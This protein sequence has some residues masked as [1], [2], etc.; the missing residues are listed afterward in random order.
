M[1]QYSI[2]GVGEDFYPNAFDRELPDEIVQVND[3]EAFEMTRRL[4][5]EE[6]LLVGGSSGMAVTAA[7]KYARE[8][9]LDEDQ[10]VVVLLPDSGRSYME[11]IFN[12]DWM[13]ANGFADIVAV[14]GLSQSIPGSKVFPHA[15]ETH[16]FDT[17]LVFYHCVIKTDFV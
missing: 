12:D 10:L 8:H 9:D 16:H 4:A 1:H 6:G 2:E 13:R 3:A 7:L 15:G 14:H 5:A 11:K 17:V